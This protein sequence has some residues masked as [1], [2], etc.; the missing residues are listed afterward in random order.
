MSPHWSNIFE[1]EKDLE[2]S[3][4]R[5]KHD[6]MGQGAKACPEL[7]IYDSFFIKWFTK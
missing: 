6:K 1:G 2:A 7:N 5:L 3:L 4:N